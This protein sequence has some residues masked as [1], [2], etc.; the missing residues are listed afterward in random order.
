MSVLEALQNLTQQERRKED[1]RSRHNRLC[2]A[3]LGKN[4]R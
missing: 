2:D 4:Q 1:E 3:S